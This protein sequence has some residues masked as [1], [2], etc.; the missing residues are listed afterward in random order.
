MKNLKITALLMAASVVLN[1]CGTRSDDGGLG[2]SSDATTVRV[3]SDV[4]SL[5]TGSSSPATISVLVTD[6]DNIAVANTDV[7]F[8]SS[9]G[10]LQDVATTTDTNGFASA[11]LNIEQDFENQDIVVTVS[12]EGSTG[13]ATVAAAGSALNVAGTNSLVS[14]DV[15]DISATLVTG[16]GDP[17]TNEPISVASSSGNTITASSLVTDSNGVISFSVSSENSSDIIMLSAINGT[18]SATHSFQV[19]TDLLT[20]TQPDAGRELAVGNDL[21]VI[22]NSVA[23][24]WTRQGVVVAGEDLIFS[25]TAGSFAEERTVTTDGDGTALVHAITDSAGPATISVVAANDSSIRSELDVEFIATDPSSILVSASTTRVDV[26][27]TSTITA[28]VQDEL[29]NPVKNSEISFSGADL[30]GGQLS[31][32]S[33]ITN[34]SGIATVSF[35]A[36][37]V[38]SPQDAISIEASVTGTD[39]SDT[40]NLTIFEQQLN[41]TMGS[42]NEIIVSDLGNQYSLQFVVQVADGSGQ[43]LEGATV[44]ASVR[45]TAYRKGVLDN[46]DGE[47]W[48]LN[49][50]NYIGCPSEDFNGDRIIGTVTTLDGNTVSEDFNENGSLDPQDPASLVALDDAETFATLSGGSLETDSTGSGF[51][52]LLYPASNAQWADVVITVRAEALG[53]EATATFATGLPT[54]AEVAS[55]VDAAPAN[56]FSPYGTVL[57]GDSGPISVPTE[58]DGVAVVVLAGCTTTN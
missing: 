12:S 18:V 50:E 39:F 38:P 21:S 47:E 29:G 41:L 40:V 11:T 35:T 19:V 1:A 55:N 24:T 25:I 7:S 54:S 6:S 17:I 36:G 30:M 56:Q 46:S 16:S 20:F 32:A 33:A 57:T 37:D 15:A 2:G 48:Q 52:N 28:F 31:P 13:Q 27:E 23:V 49:A 34:S 42:S 14:G 3:L 43:P 58:E 5:P 10:V 53:E 9:G 8:S 51:F 45:P 44:S 4:A 26:G 22:D